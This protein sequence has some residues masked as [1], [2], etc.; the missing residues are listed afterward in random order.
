MAVNLNPSIKQKVQPLFSESAQFRRSRERVNSS[1]MYR[2]IKLKFSHIFFSF[3]LLCS[4]FLGIQQGYLYLITCEEFQIKSVE[5]VCGNASIKTDTQ[6]YIQNRRLGNLFLLDM[7][8]LKQSV[9][10][11]PRIK[12]VRIR[13]LFPSSLK[14]TIEERKPAAVM[15]KEKYLLMDRDGVVL[16]ESEKRIHPDLPLLVDEGNFQKNPGEKL[17]MAWR[18]LEELEPEIQ[19]QVD[20]MDFSRYNCLTVK[21]RGRSERLILGNKEFSNKIKTFLDNVNVFS[22]FGELRSIDLRFPDRFILTPR[23]HAA[24]IQHPG[25]RKEES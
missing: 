16:A 21:L 23:D 20:T 19:K 9:V 10:S 22:K 1:K 24:G 5:I 6:S 3:L 13:K 2:R 14:I 7:Q 17:S 15:I 11:H 12:D 4:F 25:D 8:K 18:C